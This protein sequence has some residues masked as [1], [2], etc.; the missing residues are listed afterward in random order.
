V[1]PP[2]A[3][4]IAVLGGGAGLAVR[5]A[6]KHAGVESVTLVDLDPAVTKLAKTHPLFTALNRRSLA[7]PRVTVVNDDAMVWL[8]AGKGLFDLILVDFP[9]PNGYS[10]GKL[11]TTRF[12][13]LA[14]RRLD[15]GGVMAVQSTSP[16]FARTSFWIVANTIEAAGFSVRPYQMTVPSFGVWGYVLASPRPFEEPKSVLP[17]LRALSSETVASLFVFGP[18]IARVEAPVNRLNDQVLV[19]TYESEWKKFD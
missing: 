1:V 10:V 15:P 6:L 11:Y 18:D 19:R 8:E 4:R 14:K 2:D 16:L 3:N 17:G 5:E 7:D 13:A 9:D 12:Y